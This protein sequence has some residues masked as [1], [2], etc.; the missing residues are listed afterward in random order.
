VGDSFDGEDVEALLALA[1]EALQGRA[2]GEEGVDIRLAFA[3]TGDGAGE[4]FGLDGLEEI[5]EGVGGEGLQGVLVVGG[6]ED[7]VGAGGQVFEDLEAV[8]AGHLDIEEECVGA[9]GLD[10][11]DGLESVGGFAGNGQAFEGC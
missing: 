5:V 11:F 6:D 7:D 3:E 2:G 10:L 8:H 9:E 4:G 1:D